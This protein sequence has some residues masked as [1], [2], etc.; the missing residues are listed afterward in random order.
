MK[1]EVST[2][3]LIKSSVYRFFPDAEVILFGSR[4]RRENHMNSD[5]DLLIII[6]GIENPERLQHQA[7]IRKTLATQN[8]LADV[9]LQSR[10]EIEI[11]RNLPGHLV[12]IALA[13]GVRV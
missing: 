5:Y 12:R 7:L 4:A 6:D 9:I 3:D 11:K 10:G 13:E 2:L 8:I 1:T